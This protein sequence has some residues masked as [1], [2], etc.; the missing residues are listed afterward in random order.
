MKRNFTLLV[1]LLF[2]SSMLAQEINLNQGSIKQKKYLQKIPYEI[3]GEHL[4]IVPVTINGKT[5]NFLFDT[6]APL[7]ISD[8][9]YKELNL[10]NL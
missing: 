6:G 3:M 9:L 10:G 8:R 4:I 1:F 2:A 5:Y 7:T